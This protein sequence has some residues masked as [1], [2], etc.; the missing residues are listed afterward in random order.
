MPTLTHL[1]VPAPGSDTP[2]LAALAALLR[3]AI[4]AVDRLMER[5]LAVAAIYQAGREDE[6]AAL[7]LAS[8]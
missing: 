3:S 4:T 8:P 7:F 5:D 2:D 6:R 1:P